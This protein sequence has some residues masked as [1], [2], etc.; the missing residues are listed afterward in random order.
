MK[1]LYIDCAMGAAGDMLSAALLELLPDADAFLVRLNGLGIPGVTYRK[2]KSVKCGVTGTHI[3]VEVNGEEEQAFFASLA[4]AHHDHEGGH[5]HHHDSHDH[6]HDD[7][8]HHHDDH[9]AH[10]HSHPHSGMH[11][12][13]HIVE[14]L[15]VP[16]DVKRD[17][18]S[19]YGLIAAAESHVHDRPVEQV[20]FHEVG[21][22]DAVADVTAVCLLM[23]EL[24]PDK[25]IASP[26]NVG[27][28]TVQ[29]AH[30]ILPVPA[31]ATAELLRGLPAYSGAVKSELCTPTGAALLRHFAG[32]FGEMPVMRTERIG[33]GMGTKDFPVA[34]CVRVLLGETEEGE[35][36]SVTELRCNVDDMTA[37]EVAFAMERLFEAGAREVFTVPVGMKKSR[38]GL[39]L[40]VVCDTADKEK[41]IRAIFRYTTTLGMREYKTRR[42]C[43]R[44]EIRSVETPLG[45]VREKV[46][47]GCGV[48]RSKFEY[49][50]LAQLARENGLTL[51]EVRKL[52]GSC[53]QA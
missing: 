2:E 44:R 53:G 9:E 45:T 33:Y 47:S 43:L 52:A 3:A 46:A 4:H 30:G 49:D 26:V 36:E 34:N 32:S 27:G 22:M 17:I 29:C 39:L 20:H 7:H 40:D 19:V 12:I 10:G 25:V 15:A 48:T 50:D 23:A 42:Y 13:Q 1:T 37:E 8:D 38:T 16:E 31:P 11:E 24:R 5:D 18:L 14:D 6:H 35:E 51:E 28:G 41:M 21:D